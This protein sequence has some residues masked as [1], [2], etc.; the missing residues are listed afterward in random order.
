MLLLLTGIGPLL[1][2]RKSTITNLVQQFLWPA[3][4]AVVTGGGAGALGVR[5]W[6]SGICFAL[7]ALRDRTRSCRSSSAART[8]GKGATGT[9]I[10]TAMIGLVG[11]SRRRYGGYIVHLGIVLMFLGF[12]GEGFKQEEQAHAQARAG[13]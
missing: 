2:W 6:A 5:V 7:C 12:A 1:A 8:S 11:R 9:D 3:R 13:R 10:F 4:G